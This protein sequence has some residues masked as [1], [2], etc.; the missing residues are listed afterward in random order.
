MR[1]H[2]QVVANSLQSKD[3]NLMEFSFNKQGFTK[4]LPESVL[5]GLRVVSR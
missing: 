3:I 2:K 4:K 5:E 1:Y